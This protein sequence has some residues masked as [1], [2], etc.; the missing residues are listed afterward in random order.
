MF[1]CCHGDYL[2]RQYF[3]KIKEMMPFSSKLD[4]L[5]NFELKFEI[6]AQKSTLKPHFELDPMK[7]G[8]VRIKVARVIK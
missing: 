6:T 5:S 8:E 4:V 3:T 1:P 7:I 2:L